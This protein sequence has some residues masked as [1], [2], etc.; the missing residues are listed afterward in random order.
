MLH[1][2]IAEMTEDFA[3]CI[4]AWQYPPPYDIYNFSN[5]DCERE[6]LQNGLHF[7]VL[8]EDFG[9]APCGFLAIGWSAQIQDS[10]L[11]EIYDDESYTDIAFGLRPELCGQGIGASFVNA[12]IAFV[13]SLFEEEGIRLTVAADN[14]RACRLYETLGF[15]ETHAFETNSVDTAGGRT[16]RMKIMML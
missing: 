15:R 13:R 8:C 11:R 14:K 16:L 7:A 6:E 2:T 4:A 3:R 12:A 9:A 1:F 10:A 5:D